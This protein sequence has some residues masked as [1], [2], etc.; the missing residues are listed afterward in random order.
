MS[1]TGVNAVGIA[2]S[3][4]LVEIRLAQDDASDLQQ[5]K[6]TKSNR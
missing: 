2:D 5:L 1:Q 6:P 4:E 3:A